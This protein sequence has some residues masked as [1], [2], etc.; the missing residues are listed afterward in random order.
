MGMID[1]RSSRRR[2]LANL[3]LSP[4]PT[5]YGCCYQM[6]LEIRP[7]MRA[8]TVPEMEDKA[9]GSHAVTGSDR[10]VLAKNSQALASFNV[11]GGI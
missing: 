4:A 7:G 3:Y 5:P 10:I 1:L 8:G 6:D 11:G 2:W 9:G